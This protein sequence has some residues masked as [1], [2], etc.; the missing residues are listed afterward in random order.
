MAALETPSADEQ[1]TFD[2]TVALPDK[3]AWLASQ[4]EAMIDA[5]QLIKGEQA[6]VLAQLAAGQQ[7]GSAGRASAASGAITGQ[8]P[9][10]VCS[11]CGRPGCQHRKLQVCGC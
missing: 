10:L 7:L 3:I 5:G 2:T 1:A 6:D 9:Q 4:M 11:A 8:Y